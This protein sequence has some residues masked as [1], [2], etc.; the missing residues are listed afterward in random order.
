MQEQK[1]KLLLETLGRL[2]RRNARENIKNIIL[3][4]HPADIANVLN[5]FEKEEKNY[6]FGVVEDN[7]LAAEVLCEVDRGVIGELIEDMAPKKVAGIFQEM[8]PDDSK[9]IIDHLPE[10]KAE[11][12][13]DIMK[14]K[15][16]KEIEELL[17]YEKDTAGGIM[18]PNFLALHEDMIIEDAIKEVRKA[19]EAE[20]VFYIYVVD[21]KNHLV[22]VVSLRQL[23][24]ASPS[25]ALRGVMA[26]RVYSVQADMDQEDVSTFVARY[27]LLAIPVVDEENKMV[28][29]ITVDDII[30][31]IG[32][33][34][35][36]DIYKMAGTHEEEMLFSK[37]MF[38]VA[39]Y[40]LPWL[41]TSLIGGVITGLLLWQFK[42]AL[43]EVIALATFI[44]VIMGMGGNVGTQ[45]STITVRGMAIG[46]IDASMV[47]KHIL[48]EMRTGAVIGI[49]CAAI[50]GV[51]ALIWH[52]NAM[53]GAVIGVSM[54]FAITMAS[55]MGALAPIVFKRL[56]IDPAIAAGPFVTTSNDIT[57]LLIYF[58]LA[59]LLLRYLT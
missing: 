41:V 33:E 12:I 3:K 46:K 20:M 52:G 9:D 17:K 50:I 15:D 42:I 26:K 2:L 53:L 4:L 39:R 59:T 31:V 58:G 10:E 23:I 44:P 47:T 45:S 36:E 24:L 13:L 34:A 18:T 19:S 27:N 55:F 14:D 7:K 6:I 35:T 40:R 51:V 43:K 11:E 38:K 57:G 32:E 8:S 49:L 16:S 25:K 29:I 30:D 22:G 28:G 48:R 5:H 37:S 54:F 21:D 56:N 1:T